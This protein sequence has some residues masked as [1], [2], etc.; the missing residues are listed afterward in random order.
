MPP[1]MK[2]AVTQGLKQEKGR[3]SAETYLPSV[4]YSDDQSL[5]LEQKSLAL[6]TANCMLKQY[7]CYTIYGVVTTAHLI[8]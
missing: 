5:Q 4:T 8:N 3:K 1:I 7:H 6:V 2:E